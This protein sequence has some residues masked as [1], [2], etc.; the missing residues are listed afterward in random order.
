MLFQRV[1][2]SGGLL[3]LCRRA[4]AGCMRGVSAAASPAALSSPGKL[5][6]G[7]GSNVVD[8]FFPMRMLPSPGDKT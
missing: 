2:A 3:P 6:F 1:S 7:S 5:V 8:L 4:G